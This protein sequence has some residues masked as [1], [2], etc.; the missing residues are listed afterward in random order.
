MLLAPILIYL[1][2]VRLAHN[3]RPGLCRLY[4]IIGGIIVFVGGATSLYL[5][6]Y[7]GDQGD[8]A[9]FF[10]QIVVIVVYMLFSI[11]L[12]AINGIIRK[13]EQRRR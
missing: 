6:A 7:T 10:F 11:V 12:L 5:A 4:R 13:R 2:T 3:L 9:A 1:A 8:I